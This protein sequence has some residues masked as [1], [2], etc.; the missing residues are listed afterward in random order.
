MTHTNI[1][2]SWLI[3]ILVLFICSFI[4]LHVCI[5]DL[6]VSAVDVRCDELGKCF[7]PLGN[8]EQTFGFGSSL[9]H[10]QCLFM[11]CVALLQT[12]I[13]FNGSPTIK[14]S[15]IIHKQTVL[16]LSPKCFLETMSTKLMPFC[17]MS[18]PG[19]CSCS[20]DFPWLCFYMRA[21]RWVFI[22]NCSCESKVSG[23]TGTLSS[24]YTTYLIHK[25]VH[26]EQSWAARSFKLRS[27]NY[28]MDL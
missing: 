9:S 2:L 15:G 23:F 27:A 6:L 8:L 14:D 7:F 11:V 18:V 1:H 10:K 21:S 19:F 12:F 26:T 20:E 25:V 5:C 16:L 17:L 4:S 22:L 3:S 13:S 28:Q 24:T